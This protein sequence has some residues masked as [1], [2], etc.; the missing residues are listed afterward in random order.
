MTPYGITG[1]ERVKVLVSKGWVQSEIT[2]NTTMKKNKPKEGGGGRKDMKGS[3]GRGV[4]WNKN[5]KFSGILKK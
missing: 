2:V 5:M 4:G 3:G 1:K